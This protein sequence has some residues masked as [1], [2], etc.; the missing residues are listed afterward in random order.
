VPIWAREAS[1]LVF[2]HA[3][4]PGYDDGRPDPDS[5]VRRARRWLHVTEPRHG[6]LSVGESRGPSAS[7]SGHLYVPLFPV[8]SMTW[9]HGPRM[10]AA[11]R[12]PTGR[13]RPADSNVSN[14]QCPGISDDARH[15]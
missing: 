13:P 10:R 1:R 8:S 12:R 3:M 14:V 7:E 11:A 15:C 2:K 5:Q 6:C 4:F 9:K